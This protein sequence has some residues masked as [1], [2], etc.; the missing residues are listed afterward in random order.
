M[1]KYTKTYLKE[2]L[3]E[4]PTFDKKIAERKESLL[5]P[6]DRQT[7]ENIGG[8]KGNTVGRPVEALGIKLAEDEIITSYREH[9]EAIE[10]S[11]KQVDVQIQEII[12]KRYFHNLKQ[13]EV[14]KACGVTIAMIR[15][16]EKSFFNKLG[17]RLKLIC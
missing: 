13:E 8:G 5:Y 17:K 10:V 2:V 15:S 16:A 9:K 7:D 11:F 6:N 4:Y 1:K 3:R 14:S 12:S